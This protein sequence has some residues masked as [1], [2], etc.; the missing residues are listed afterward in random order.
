[1]LSL[2]VKN[3]RPPLQLTFS[4]QNYFSPQKYFCSEIDSL[5]KCYLRVTHV[6]CTSHINCYFVAV[7]ICL[8]AVKEQKVKY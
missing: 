7:V 1:M 3:L 6:C 4:V 2:Y 5:A 8:E